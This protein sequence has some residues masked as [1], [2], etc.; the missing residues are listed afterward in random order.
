MVGPG[1]RLKLTGA[2]AAAL[3]YA[4][5]AAM[6][7]HTEKLP[8][9]CVEGWSTRQEWTG[10]RLRDLAE[11]LGM[12]DGQ[13]L[14]VISLQEAGA[15]R[16]TT[17]SRDQVMNEK[18]L[19]ALQVNGERPGD[20]P[21]L[22][23]A[24]H[25]PGAARGAQHQVGH[26]AEGRARMISAWKKVYGASPLHLLGQIVAFAVA[27]Y[28]YLQIID[29]TSTD[30]LNL[31]LWFV[32]GALL[33]DAVFVPIY[34]ILDLIARL[35]I[36]DHALRDVRAIN[37]IRFPIAICGVMF[38]TLFPLI[39]QKGK[40]NYERTAGLQPPDYLARWALICAVVFGVSAVSYAVRLRLDAMRATKAAADQAQGP[41]ASVTA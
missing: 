26:R 39:I 3:T 28:A 19:L 10:V 37:H 33:H 15:F 32:L 8:I 18:S 31:V 35:G 6:E 5:V 14:Q 16:Q 1:F 24:H 38:L 36:Q 17:L 27:V 23:D 4:E 20:G 30:N 21:R 9:A 25:R 2:S 34:V 22:P 13:A 41:P 11:R 40:A 29:V 12:R 7:Q